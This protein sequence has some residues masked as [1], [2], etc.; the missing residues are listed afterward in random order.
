MLD[1]H[2]PSTRVTASKVSKGTRSNENAPT[3]DWSESDGNR[4]EMLSA[5]SYPGNVGKAAL[6]SLGLAFEPLACELLYC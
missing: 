3:G 4:D 5:T 1:D 2:E 6:Y